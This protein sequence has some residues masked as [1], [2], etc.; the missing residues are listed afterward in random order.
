MSAGAFESGRYISNVGFV[1]PCRV[2]PE[3]K[4]LVLNS[5]ANAYPGAAVDV[6]L[7][8]IKIS[9]GN[10]EAGVVPR[11]VV[12]ELTASGSGVTAEYTEG[13]QL[14][15]PI[16]QQTV[17]DGLAKDQTGT[18]QGIACKVVSVLPERVN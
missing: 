12:V 6:G 2:Q 1:F 4:G 15:I 18:Y 5:V 14:T 7:P 16:F 8:S 17:F 9:N 13:N 11:K 10:R 3:T